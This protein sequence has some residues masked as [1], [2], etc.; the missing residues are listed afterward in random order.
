[1]QLNLEQRIND[2]KTKVQ[3]AGKISTPPTMTSKRTLSPASVST[4]ISPASKRPHKGLVAREL[5]P[6]KPQHKSESAPTSQGRL[7]TAIHFQPH[8]VPKPIVPLSPYE[9]MESLNSRISYPSSQRGVVVPP[10]I[11]SNT[12]VSSSCENM[13]PIMAHSP[14]RIPVRAEINIDVSGSAD[15]MVC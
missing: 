4:G 2:L 11:P 15:V 6:F 14:S 3:S 9:N 7:L 1:M 13:A 10:T 5:F 12:V 8:I